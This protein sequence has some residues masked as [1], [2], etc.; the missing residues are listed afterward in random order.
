MPRI[1]ILHA[2]IGTGHTTAANAL[3]DAFRRKQSG[4][5][6]VEDILAYG[7]ELL[8]KALTQAYLQ[9]SSHAPLLWKMLY[10]STDQ[11]DPDVVAVTNAILA[12]IER[13]LSRLERSWLAHLVMP[14]VEDDVEL[15]PAR[16]QQRLTAA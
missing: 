10:T 6:R 7:S 12:R 14:A 2:S 1:L 3:A 4:E 15:R 13:P 8:R 5:V 11:G 16:C 9:M